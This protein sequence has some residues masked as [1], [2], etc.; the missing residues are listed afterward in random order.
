MIE[1]RSN[2]TVKIDLHVHTAFGSPCAELHKPET[3]VESLKKS[4]IQGIVITEHNTMW[5]PHHIEALN[6][7]LPKHL[8]IY[9]G[10]EVSTSSYHVVVIGLPDESGIIPG[11]PHEKLIEIT[12]NF[13]AVTILV[14][15]L[16]TSPKGLASG[17]LPDVDC[18]E[19]ASTM[20]CG[21]KQ[22]QTCNL[23]FQLKLIPVAGS[24][25]H[26]R[27]NIGKAYTAFPRLPR[28]EHELAAL[29]KQGLGVP[30]Q[31]TMG[32]DVSVC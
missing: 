16:S 28:D 2:G 18:I 30:M 27:E 14:H 20:T 8:R 15:P 25:A 23:C 29:I 24:D 17:K 11:M 9:S 21:E 31:T 4:P 32:K 12:K 26:C 19:V 6:R 10:I 3:L 22:Q 7:S 5:P 1:Y 13:N